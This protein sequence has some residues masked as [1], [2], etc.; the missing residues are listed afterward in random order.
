M[1]TVYEN[2]VEALDL[3]IQ[4]ERPAAEIEKLRADIVRFDAAGLEGGLTEHA[5]AETIDRDF[6]Y[7]DFDRR[8]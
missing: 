6:D 3:A 4:L 8:R 2:L 5:R 1:P 7:E